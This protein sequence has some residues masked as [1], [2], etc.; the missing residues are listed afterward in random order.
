[1]YQADD[2]GD[3]LLQVYIR[4]SGVR[5]DVVLFSVISR[6]IIVVVRVVVVIIVSIM[7]Y[8]S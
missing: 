1:M 3:D 8:S 4:V 7:A 5:K 2:D 6:I